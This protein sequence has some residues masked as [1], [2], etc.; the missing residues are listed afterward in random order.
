MALRHSRKE[1][2]I[3]AKNN[4]FSDKEAQPLDVDYD[5]CYHGN[6]DNV[7][8]AT[9]VRIDGCDEMPCQVP[10]GQDIKAQ[11]DFTTGKPA[12]KL[13][14]QVRVKAL[15]FWVDYPIGYDDACPHLSA[16]KCPLS[17]GDSATYDIQIPV[18]PSYPKISIE[19]EV[20]L[21]NE[22]GDSLSCFLVAGEVVD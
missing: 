1:M 11:M 21:K 9:A 18:L 10:R 22:N 6:D 19:V 5:G 3:L 4:G 12:S 16:G 14:V 20:T 8:P 7:P 15:G 17:P 2:K 13:T